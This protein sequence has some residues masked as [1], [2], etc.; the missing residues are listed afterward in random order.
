MTRP[1][2]MT[3]RGLP[4]PSSALP[5][6]EIPGA[7]KSLADAIGEQLTYIGGGLTL[8]TF[9][10]VLSITEVVDSGSPNGGRAGTFTV[11]FPRLATVAGMVC[12]AGTTL[13]GEDEK[14]YAGA[15]PGA[16]AQGWWAPC[17][18]MGGSRAYTPRSLTIHAVGWGTPR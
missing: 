16:G 13:G 2:G 10:G 1:G 11:P 6:T 3:P 12:C 18:W 4:Y 9:A 5:L 7:I 17:A 8:D 15:D 14:G